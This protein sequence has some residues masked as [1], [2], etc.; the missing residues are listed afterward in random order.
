MRNWNKSWEIFHEIFDQETTRKSRDIFIYIMSNLQ[1]KNSQIRICYYKN[2]N[3][4]KLPA[5]YFSHH[6][7]RLSHVSSHELS[8]SRLINLRAML[9]NHPAMM[10][11]CR[12]KV[13]YIVQC[14]TSLN[15]ADRRRWF[16][17]YCMRSKLWYNEEGATSWRSHLWSNTISH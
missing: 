14:L 1:I 16:T 2:T 8:M 11:P 12:L 10:L 17:I 7:V 15:I 3:T 4:G 9:I 5:A 13:V 6:V